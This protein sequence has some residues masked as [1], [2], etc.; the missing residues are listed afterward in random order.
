[1]RR[2]LF[3]A[4][5]ISA[6]LFAAFLSTANA[7]DL[8]VKAPPPAPVYVCTFC[9]WYVGLNAGF[10]ITSGNGIANTGTDT[11][12][13][14]LGS[15]LVGTPPGLP[16]EADA[17]P[18]GFVGGGQFGYNWQYARGFL[19]GVEGDFDG[20]AAKKTFIAGPS[21]GASNI[22]AINFAP[23]TGIFH[24]EWDWVSTLRARFGVQVLN[25]SFMPYV[26]A[27]GAAAE[28][29]IGNQF[30]CLTCAPSTATE[31]GTVGSNS[32]TRFGGAAGAGFEWMIVPKF[33]IKAEYMYVEVGSSHSTL[34]YVGTAGGGA[35]PST[36][37]MTSTA[38][39]GLN[40]MR[41]GINWY[42]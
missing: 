18:Q 17:N 2:I 12:L 38:R 25:G 31:A 32:I 30:V 33:T 29:K 40:I 21:I 34:T 37:T 15:I 24:R 28:V 6:A 14:G 22:T 4:G 3:G 1:M 35:G 11:G 8:G 36:S 26:T 9:G 5:F 20:V 23:T 10:G 39:N 13:G 19:L 27:G 16:L 41:G 42:F 7:A